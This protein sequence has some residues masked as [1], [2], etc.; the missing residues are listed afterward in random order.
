MNRL[1]AYVGDLHAGFLGHGLVEIEF[2]VGIG[3]GHHL[4]AHNPYLRTD[5]GLF[6]LVEHIAAHCV[7]SLSVLH[8]AD[9]HDAIVLSDLA[10]NVGHHL[11]DDL[12]GH[13]IG[14][15]HGDAQVLHFVGIVEKL[16]A[17]LALHL[18]EKLLNRGILHGHRDARLVKGLSRQ[19]L[20]NEY[21]QEE[22]QHTFYISF[23]HLIECF[24]WIT[25]CF[26]F[27]CS[28]RA[29][30]FAAQSSLRKPS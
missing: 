9:N 8:Q 6:V 16:D 27:S 14:L 18:V 1:H 25:F 5:N 29:Y 28:P 12:S 17:C 23:L 20:G 26:R 22:C 24:L 10:S 13:S 11:C 19:H 7:P 3:N 21:H 2:T 4:G 15:P 30:H